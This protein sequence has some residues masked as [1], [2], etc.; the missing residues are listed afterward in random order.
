MS[1]TK[2]APIYGYYSHNHASMPGCEIRIFRHP[3]GREVLVTG[4]GSTENPEDSGYDYPQTLE[5]GKITA[6]WKLLH[7]YRVKGVDPQYLL[8]PEEI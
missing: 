7:L 8:D 5:V 3:Q 1:N 4:F 2:T 6:K